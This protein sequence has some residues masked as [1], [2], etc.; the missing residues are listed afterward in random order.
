MV[1]E[2]SP[3]IFN[4][5]KLPK[6]VKSN[7]FISV[8]TTTHTLR[9]KIFKCMKNVER[10][11]EQITSME[12]GEIGEAQE[13]FVDG[14]YGDFQK[15]YGQLK[16]RLKDHEEKTS[17][18]KTMAGYI[19]NSNINSNQPVAVKTKDDATNALTE[20]DKHEDD[21][22]KTVQDWKTANL[23]FLAGRKRKK[24]EPRVAV[25]Q[26]EAKSTDNRV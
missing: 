25:N 15:E 20:A 2:D 11:V 1:G 13:D 22:E 4:E 21:L 8:I 6:T 19:Y 3:T 26:T 23:K 5:K 18:I 12:Q 17:Q 10:T 7:Q 16:D 9:T 24:S 14:L